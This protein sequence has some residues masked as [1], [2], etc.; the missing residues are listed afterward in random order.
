MKS[1][2][3]PGGGGGAGEPEPGRLKA[4]RED[5]AFVHTDSHEDFMDLLLAKRR[6]LELRVTAQQE[7]R[8]ARS[9]ATRGGV[10][11][12]GKVRSAQPFLPLCNSV[13]LYMCVHLY[14]HVQCTC[15]CICTM[16]VNTGEHEHMYMYT[17][18]PV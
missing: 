15:T 11:D 2:E 16:Y 13:V 1:L 7:G 12:E 8:R 3:G 14:V 18:M 6:R 5:Y 9:H 10:A 17:C 4:R